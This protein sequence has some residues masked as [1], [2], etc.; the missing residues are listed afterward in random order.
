[1]GRTEASFGRVA[2]WGRVGVGE[3]ERVRPSEVGARVTS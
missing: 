3:L 2:G 1:M